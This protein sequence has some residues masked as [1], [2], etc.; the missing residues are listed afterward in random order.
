[1]LLGLGAG[2]AARLIIERFGPV[3]LVGVDDDP[4][5]LEIAREVL[6]DLPSVEFV[7]DDAFA[8]A[9]RA[10]AAGEHFDYIAVDLYH[11]NRLSHGIVGRPFLKALKTLLEPRNLACFNLFLD[12]RALDRVRRI[13]RVLTV[14][15]RRMVGKNLIIWVR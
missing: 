10:S 4:A 5:V 8:Y 13:E 9:E 14:Q 2:T 6:Q 1:L 11:G 15:D 7:H 12:R 3:P